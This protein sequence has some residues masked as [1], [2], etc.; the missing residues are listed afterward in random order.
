MNGGEKTIREGMEAFISTE[1]KGETNEIHK[2]QKGTFKKRSNLFK[3]IRHPSHSDATSLG[4]FCKV[5]T[6]GVWWRVNSIMVLQ[7]RQDTE[8]RP[9][10]YG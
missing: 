8:D 6:K 10:L 4:A 9:C 2:R 7:R 5:F 3:S 1:K